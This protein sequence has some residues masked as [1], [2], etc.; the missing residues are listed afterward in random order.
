MHRV[1]PGD[2]GRFPSFPGIEWWRNL[3][4]IV[5]NSDGSK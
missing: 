2:K 1:N 5:M 3:R 4:I